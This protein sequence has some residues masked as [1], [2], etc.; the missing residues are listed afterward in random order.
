[1]LGFVYLRAP[2]VFIAAAL[3]AGCLP[4]DSTTAEDSLTVES[5][6]V[7][8][9]ETP[10]VAVSET[11]T[12]PP[13][14]V[15]VSP[16]PSSFPSP[17]P[18]E[19]SQVEVV[20]PQSVYEVGEVISYTIINHSD[21]PIY[22]R[23]SGCDFPYIVQWVDDEEVTLAINITEEVPALRDIGPGGS[24][25]CSWDQTFHPY[26]GSD[27]DVQGHRYQV[28]FWYAFTEKDVDVPGGLLMARSQVF[29]IE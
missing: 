1:M 23:Y 9:A 26:G 24:L 29:T 13:T 19:I 25:A 12:T 10:T 8:F 15:A 20:V 14:V 7:E 28:R 16:S 3:F 27:P 4:T 17:L 6:T 11:S 5:A 22:Y 2:L 21:K 18:P